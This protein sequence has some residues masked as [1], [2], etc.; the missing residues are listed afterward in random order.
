MRVKSFAASHYLVVDYRQCHLSIETVSSWQWA[1]QCMCVCVCFCCLSHLV[2]HWSSSSDVPLTQ[3]ACLP[4]CLSTSSLFGALLN[5]SFARSQ[6]PFH[7]TRSSGGLQVGFSSSLFRFFISL[8]SFSY[9]I[10]GH[11]RDA[12][13]LSAFVSPFDPDILPTVSQS[14]PL[15]SPLS[16]HPSRGD[17]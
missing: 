3:S 6:A 8:F 7:S 16:L 9:R 4:A 5:G 10:V 14:F 1:W 13:L 15:F 2:C 12:G 17:E 11:L